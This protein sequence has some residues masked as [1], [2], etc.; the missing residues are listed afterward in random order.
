VELRKHDETPLE[1]LA[2]TVVEPVDSKVILLW[3]KQ[4]SVS[5]LAGIFILMHCLSELNSPKIIFY[6]LLFN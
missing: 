4:Q 3:E 1:L 6:P 2:G 5:T